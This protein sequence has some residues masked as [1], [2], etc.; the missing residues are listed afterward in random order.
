MKRSLLICAATVMM[1]VSVPQVNADD[2]RLTL[3]LNNTLRGNALGGGSWTLSARKVETGA[4]SQGDSGIAGIRAL[5]NN[6]TIGSI[7][8]SGTINQQAG[9]PYTQ[10]LSNGTIEIVYGQDISVPA[11]VV[12]GVGVAANANLDRIIATGTWP[13]GPRPTFGVDTS[14]PTPFASE[15]N[16]LNGLVAPFAGVSATNTVTAIVTLG[17]F[18]NTGTISNADT[19]GYVA[20]LTGGAGAF[21]PAGD[22]NQSGSVTNADTASYVA[23]LTGPLSASFS[24]VPEPSTIGLLILSGIGL[25]SRRR[26]V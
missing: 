10:T 17:D 20:A 12:T 5:I 19:G 1:L 3:D 26:R 2:I 8:F 14:T 7:A 22:F 21:N 25:I 15:G 23:E 9:G 11:S 18:N 24:V 16:F 6:I 4:G 13:A